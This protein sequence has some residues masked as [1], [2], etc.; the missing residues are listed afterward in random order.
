MFGIQLNRPSLTFLSS[1]LAIIAWICSLE[2]LP[3]I[4]CFIC[5]FFTE[6]YCFE[7]I[8]TFYYPQT[9]FKA[10]NS[11]IV[12][13]ELLIIESFIF[14][15]SL[16]NKQINSTLVENFPLILSPPYYTEY[17]SVDCVAFQTLHRRYWLAP[18]TTLT[19]LP[20]ESSSKQGEWI[21]SHKSFLQSQ[22]I[23]ISSKFKS[24]LSNTGLPFSDSE[25]LK[26]LLLDELSEEL[27]RMEQSEHLSV[28]ICPF[29]CACL[30]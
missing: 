13:L 4:N 22:I 21:Y 1:F 27:L 17:V 6:Q 24:L 18:Q 11:P 25:L 12:A 28:W 2:M 5:F 23:R 20:P 15:D 29:V 10:L 26:E 9:F 7:T 19:K 3:D 30:L 16:P 8:K 14:F